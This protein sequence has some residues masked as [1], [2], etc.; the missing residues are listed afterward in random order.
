[1]L[2]TESAIPKT[3]AGSQPQPAASADPGTEY[4]RDAALDERAG[5]RDRANGQQLLDVELQADAEHQQDDAD[6]GELLGEMLV[7][8][9]ARRVRADQ[10]PREEIADDGRQAEPMG[11]VASGQRRR[12]TSGQ[13]HDQVERVH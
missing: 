10:Q 11:Q 3:I 13:R 9:E 1:M 7:R 6:L 4:R 5:N 8:D 12:E 2:A